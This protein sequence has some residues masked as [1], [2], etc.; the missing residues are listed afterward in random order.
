VNENSKE[1]FDLKL[2]VFVLSILLGIMFLVLVPVHLINLQA[3]SSDALNQIAQKASQAETQIG[4]QSV[5][6]QAIANNPQSLQQLESRVKEIDTAIS[7]KQ[8]QGQ[9]LTPEQIQNLQ[10]TQKQLQT[11]R[12]L[13]K[14]PTALKTRLDELQVQL[15]NEKLQRES[16]AKTEAIEQGLRIGASSLMLAIGYL[17]IGGVGLQKISGTGVGSQTINASH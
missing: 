16:L 6:L 9:K 7:Q 5:Q 10:N 12:E 1:A 11:F 14:N 15:Q 4:E 17:I 3:V 13:A 8:F 2:P